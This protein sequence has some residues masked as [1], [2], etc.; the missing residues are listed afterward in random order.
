MNGLGR[1]LG[2][3]GHHLVECESHSQE[4][5]HHLGHAVDGD[6]PARHRKVGADA[7]GQHA[8]IQD[9]LSHVESKIHPAVGGIQPNAPVMG[10][11]RLRNQLPVAVQH[12]SGVAGEVMSHDVAFV[13]DGQ[14]FAD[15]VGVVALQRVADVDHQRHSGFHGSPFGHPGHLHSHDLQG[16]R[17]HPGF[18]AGNH[19]IAALDGLDCLVQVDAFRAEDVWVGGQ[20]GS[21]D[22]QE[23]DDLSGGVG[24]DVGRE[25]GKSVAPRASRIHHGGD[26]GTDAADVGIDPVVG[27]AGVDV[28]VQVDETGSD[29]L[30]VNFNDPFGFLRRDVHGN[31]GNLAV[32]YGNVGDAVEVLGR[33]DDSAAFHD[34]VIHGKRAS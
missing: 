13:E 16:R 29:D 30:A 27:D 18:N 17:D 34:Q 32:F 6:L 23:A 8:L 19:A 33:V 10:F 9:F 1:I 28:G 4:P 24:N 2:G 20:A 15:H 3:H 12:A 31:L 14:Q 11:F 21:A 25:P 5:G 7:V 22:V 26:S